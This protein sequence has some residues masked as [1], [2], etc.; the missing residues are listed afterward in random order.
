MRFVRFDDG[1]EPRW[2]RVE[3][4]TIEALDAAP[5]AGGVPTGAR[6]PVA[7][8]RLLAPCAP[9]KIVCV[10]RNYAA[11]AAELGNEVPAEPLIFLKP[12]SAVIGPGEPI[13]LPRASGNVQHEAELALVIGARCRNVGAEEAPAL[14][15]GHTCLNDVTARDIQ[16]AEGKFTR[17]KG[18]DTF[19]PVGPW[20]VPGMP[21]PSVRVRCFVNGEVRQDGSTAQ[22]IHTPAA[23]VAF[24]SR[25]MTLEPGDLISTG[26]PA[27]VGRLVAGD[28]VEVEVEG[29]GVLANPVQSEE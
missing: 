20:I 28:R 12:P 9:T 14:V 13:V 29:V 25:V 5:W 1:G 21:A 23:L 10:G 19:C 26:T 8:A 16:Q 4:E 15:F 6:T 18:F 7:G 3:G 11:H 2:G 27:G 22:M 17:A 24:V